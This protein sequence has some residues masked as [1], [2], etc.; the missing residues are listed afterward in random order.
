M[1]HVHGG[2]L[3][4][5]KACVDFLLLCPPKTGSTALTEMLLQHPGIGSCKSSIGTAEPGYW[6]QCDDHINKKT[7]RHYN[8]MFSNQNG[9]L[10]EKSTQYLSSPD[11]P[12]NLSKHN[13]AN[14]K[15]I[16]VLRDPIERVE[17]FFQHFGTSKQIYKDEKLYEE[18][19]RHP[20]V[21]KLSQE[22]REQ[23]KNDQSRMVVESD[24]DSVFTL[25]FVNFL[26]DN[27][28]NI[29]DHLGRKWRAKGH[30]SEIQWQIL[31]SN[32]AIG[33]NNWLN[34][35]SK[36]Q[37][38]FINYKKYKQD[39]LGTVASILEFLSVNMSIIESLKLNQGDDWGKWKLITDEQRRIPDQYRDIL[40]P[41]YKKSNDYIKHKFD[42]K[43]Y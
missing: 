20:W 37:F 1:Q 3:L 30:M 31:T 18:Y 13:K 42:I 41:F 35:F 6:H 39:N 36:S 17:S 16:C 11:A 40:R 24:W 38:M 34:V 7:L 43:L 9:L 33:L 12:H 28:N 5:V 4:P 19:S 27:K 23:F 26:D 2:L 10:F 15:L 25:E 22:Q 8:E 29:Q 14:I 32:Y 21:Q